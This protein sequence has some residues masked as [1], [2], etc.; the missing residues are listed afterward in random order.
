M[1]KAIYLILTFFLCS[2]QGFA[3]SP[4]LTTISVP[5]PNHAG[6]TIDCGPEGSETKDSKIKSAHLAWIGNPNKN[7]FDTPAASDINTFDINDLISSEANST[8]FTQGTPI[9]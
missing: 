1:K 3:Q 4:D 6:Q 5:D 9:Q 7:R 8:K 2:I